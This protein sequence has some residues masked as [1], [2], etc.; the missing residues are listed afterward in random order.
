MSVSEFSPNEYQPCPL[1]FYEF[2]QLQHLT[3]CVL[4]SSVLDRTADDDIQLDELDGLKAD[5]LSLQASVHNRINLLESELMVLNEW[6]V[7]K[8]QRS[9]STVSVS[10]PIKR[11]RSESESSTVGRKAKQVKLQDPFD[12]EPR[13][14]SQPI[15]KLDA[16]DR[17]WSSVEP[18][19]SDITNNDLTLLYENNMTHDEEQEY[20]KIPPLGKHYAQKW[21]MVEMQKEQQFG[22]MEEKLSDTATPSL[23]EIKKAACP[24]GPLTQRLI[25]AFVEDNPTETK[26]LLGRLPDGKP[27]PVVEPNCLEERIKRE[28]VSLGLCDETEVKA[29]PD[30]DE[31]L[32]ELKRKQEELKTVVAYNRAQREKLENAA[33][34][35]MKRQEI[36]RQAKEA[37][38]D[39]LK[40]LRMIAQYKQ[41][42]KAPSKKEKDAA[43]KAIRNRNNIYSQLDSLISS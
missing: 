33:K 31:I 12:E 6:V 16:V 43:W 19:C 23:D 30:D 8:K 35:E 34:V 40:W 18:Y 20:Y 36:K 28:L 22:D 26:P 15:R 13:D 5:L 11:K 25:S 17:F 41:K 37:D 10:V 42:K 24:Y 3:N 7:P 32:T 2:R 21:A 29:K 27:V 38:E 4:Y 9:E 14:A 39:V 1:Q